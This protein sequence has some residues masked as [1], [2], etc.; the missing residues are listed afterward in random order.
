M[1]PMRAVLS[2]APLPPRPPSRRA[3]LAAGPA[4]ALSGCVGMGLPPHATLSPPPPPPPPPPD[5]AFTLR[6]GARLPYR[7]WLPQGAPTVA[8]LALHGMNDSRDAW[9]IPAG[10]LTAAG[11]AIYAPDQRGF[12]AAPRRGRWAGA[13]TLVADAAD[14]A[15]QVRARHPDMPLVLLGE[16]MGGAVL[17]CLA[18]GPLAPADARYVLVAPAVWGRAEMNV[19]LRGGLWLGATLLPSLAMSGAPVRVTASDN[20]AALIRLSRDP[21]TLRETRF[22]TLRG[23]VDLMDAAQAAAPRFV[24]PGL[25]L[26][27][28]RDELVPKAATA[29]TWRALPRGGRWRLA[30]YPHDYHLMLRDLERAAPLGDVISWVRTPDAPLPSGAGVAAAHWLASHEA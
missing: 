6:D 13:P 12:G 25:F 26:Y 2:T 21:L 7:A 30:Y 17:M 9:E 11:F 14:M 18:T 22:D 19:F 5:G 8:V 20:R 27:G 10:A 16:S 29:A 4:L 23:L 24:A 1:I 3:V 28:G 15:G